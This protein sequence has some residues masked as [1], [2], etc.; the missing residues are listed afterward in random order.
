RLRLSIKAD[1][2]NITELQPSGEDFEY[3]FEV[4]CSSCDEIHPKYVSMNR[5]EEQEVSGGKHATAHFV[6]RCSFCKRESSGKFETSSKVRPYTSEN[7]QFQPLLI[8]ECRGLEFT[9]FYPQGI[10]KCVGLTGTKF[11]KVDLTEGEWFDYDEKAALPVG[12]SNIESQ[13]SRA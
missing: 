2:E 10:W 4:K 8:I 6:W 11:D 5:K 9:G 3:F 1:L 13:W 7:E 12:V